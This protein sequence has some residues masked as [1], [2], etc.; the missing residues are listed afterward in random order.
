MIVGWKIG[1]VLLK[2]GEKDEG[3]EQAFGFVDE[4]GNVDILS[5]ISLEL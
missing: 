1:M 5:I 2:T 3:Q 4:A